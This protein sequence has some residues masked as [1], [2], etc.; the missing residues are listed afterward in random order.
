MASESP[1]I[2][3]T[4][5]APPD[6]P[7]EGSLSETTFK[8]SESRFSRTPLCSGGRAECAADHGRRHR[9]RPHERVRRAGEY[10]GV[11]SAGEA[12]DLASLTSTPRRSAPRRGPLAHRAQPHSVGMGCI[13]EASVGFPGLQRRHPAQRRHGAGDPAPKRIRHSVDRQDPPHP[14]ARDHRRRTV[15][16]VADGHGRGVFLRL[17]RRRCEPVVSAAVGELHAHE[18]AEN[19]GRGLSLGSRHGRQDHRLHQPAKVDPSREAVDRLLRPATGTSRRSAC[20][21]SSSR[22]TAASSTTATTCCVTVFWRGRRSLGSSR[23]TPQLAPRPEVLPPWDELTDT[24]KKSERAGWKSSAAR[25]NTPITRSGRIVEAIE[26]DRR[27]GQHADHLH[28]R[29]TTARHP[30]VA[31]TAR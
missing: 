4:V 15:R 8:D 18:G 21:T 28:R 23:R 24:D 3:R 14:D 7:F 1:R 31:C 27:A 10:A 5:S 30:K 9:L 19:S 22:D 2:D 17:L 11:R 13:P 12:R 25:W 26:A 20:P 29:A 16:P 6:P